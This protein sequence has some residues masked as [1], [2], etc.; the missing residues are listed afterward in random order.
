MLLAQFRETVGRYAFVLEICLS[1][2]SQAEFKSNFLLGA[3]IV[4][5]NNM[6]VC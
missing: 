3:A 1:A 6:E 5:V 2:F 4:F